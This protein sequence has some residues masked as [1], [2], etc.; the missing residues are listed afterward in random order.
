VSV[1]AGPPETAG[2]GAA[3]ENPLLDRRLL[4]LVFFFAVYFY[5]LYQ[6]A[7]VLSPFLAPLVGAVMIVLI[8]HPL[9]AR[10]QRRIHGPAAAAAASTAIVLMT[11]VVP[12]IVLLWLLVREAA[13]IAPVVSDWL[14]KRQDLATAI[15]DHRLPAPIAKVWIKVAAFIE[16][17]QIDLRSVALEALREVG[18]SITKI[19]AATL[20]QFFGLILDLIV[21]VLT[22][23]FFF[24]DGGRIVRWILDMVPMEERN[25]QLIF[26]RLDRTLS[27]IVRGAFITASA[28]G[29]LAGI[30]LAVTGVPFPVL[31]GFASALF[32]LIPFVGASLIWAP[33]AIYL[34]FTGHAVAAI[35][36]AVWGALVVGLVDN[37]LRPYVIGE[38]A[39]LPILLILVGVLGGI[40]VFGLIGVLVSPLLI[41]SVLAFAQIYRE[42]YVAVTQAPP[43]PPAQG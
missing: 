5:L 40:Q 13:D 10:L 22:L 37:F 24:R 21:L 18:N 26:G 16:K 35:V 36:M 31:L 11:I 27:A 8:F 34:Y 25:K 1:P 6:L 30:G 33:A 3:P 14:S 7:R 39:Q 29:L 28:Q 2:S 43:A 23:F 32:S 42:Q 9:H 4:F 17:W 19:G 38:Q 41:A 20:K 12:I 15:Q